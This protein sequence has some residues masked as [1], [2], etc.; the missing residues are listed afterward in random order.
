MPIGQQLPNVS[1]RK[2]NTQRYNSPPALWSHIHPTN[3]PS[4]FLSLLPSNA[5]TGVLFCCF[6]SCLALLCISSLF[7]IL[8]RVCFC[9]AHSPTWLVCLDLSQIE[10]ERRHYRPHNLRLL[11]GKRKERPCTSFPI[12]STSLGHS[13]LWPP[14]LPITPASPTLDSLTHT[15]TTTDVRY[16]CTCFFPPASNRRPA[17]CRF[18][19]SPTSPSSTLSRPNTTTHSTWADRSRH[20]IDHST[21][22]HD[23]PILHKRLSTSHAA[24]SFV[25]LC[26]TASSQTILTISLSDVLA[27][28]AIVGILT[29]TYPHPYVDS[30]FPLSPSSLSDSRHPQQKSTDKRRLLSPPP[31]LSLQV[32]DIHF[33]FLTAFFRL[34]VRPRPDLQQPSPPP[35]V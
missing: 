35:A 33:Y 31:R 3:R 15:T 18:S 10:K 19:A 26:L 17:S 21:Y 6:D 30:P 13:F 11:H 22:T 27:I 23:H 9:L 14:L 8:L 32:F 1:P 2:N 4:P 34:P 20:T 12:L 5:S 7:G 29:T 24:T 25:S 16:F 28:H